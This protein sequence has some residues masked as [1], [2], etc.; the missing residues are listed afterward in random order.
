MNKI[1]LRNLDFEGIDILIMKSLE[2][3]FEKNDRL[4]L[5]LSF[6]GSWLRGDL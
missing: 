3:G 6:F 1:W 5:T 4:S 2:K